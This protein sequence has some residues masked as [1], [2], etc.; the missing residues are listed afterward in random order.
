MI[1]PPGVGSYLPKSSSLF[2]IYILYLNIYL[3]DHGAQLE[4]EMLDRV[5]IP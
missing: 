4:V 5:A 3:E 2:L 1:M